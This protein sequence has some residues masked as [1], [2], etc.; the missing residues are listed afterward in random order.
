MAKRSGELPMRDYRPRSMLALPAHVPERA[1]FPVID[2]H[3]HLFGELSPEALLEVMDQVGVST[4]VNVSGNVAMP[5]DEAGYTIRVEGIDGFLDDY[6][7]AHPGRFAA[8]TMSGFARWGDF[9]VFRES[10]FVERVIADLEEHIGKGALGLKVTKELGLQF[11]DPHGAMVPVDDERFFPVW[12]RAG[13]LGVPVLMHTSDPV[14]FFL[15]VDEANEHYA[16]LRRFP[17][18]SFCGS[19]FSKEELLEQRNRVVALHPETTFI[20]PHVANHAE[21]LASVAALLD[22]HANVCIDFSARIDELGRQPRAAREFMI[23]YQDRVLFG[24]DMPVSVETYRCHFR[25]LESR[26]EWFEY[27]DYVGRWG[28]SRWGISGLDLPDEVLKNIYH[29]N[30]VRIIPGLSAP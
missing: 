6:V 24:T 12:K 30:A 27:P 28:H 11:R 2:A 23:A 20:L 17:G 5:F 22:A 8:L 3:N 1:R 25:F 19:H 29:R 4:F 15:P 18:W 10:D 13:E 7:A 16:N 9:T 26:D 14:A 21:D